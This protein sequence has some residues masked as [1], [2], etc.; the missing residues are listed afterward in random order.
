MIFDKLRIASALW[1]PDIQPVVESAVLI[2]LPID[3]H[4]TL[5]TRMS[6]WQLMSTGQFKLPYR[7]TAIEDLASCVIIADK[8]AGQQGLEDDRIF[9][10]CV[11]AGP[12][13]DESHY[14]D[15][16]E[17]TREMA[18]MC[19]TMPA[20]TVIITVGHFSSMAQR[21]N[22]YLVDGAVTHAIVCAGNVLLVA[23]GAFG[24]MGD[25]E[26]KQTS[27]SSL[28]NAMTSV[29]EIMFLESCPGFSGWPPLDLPTTLTATSDGRIDIQ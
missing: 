7:I 1:L 18:G 9:I 4:K 26:R 27:E 19:A 12:D 13:V 3:P 11:P 2:R 16:T 14:N 17:A 22:G 15:T 21:S 28:R 20:D 23:P 24:C 10:E 25:R 8:F 29:E 6:T 5:P